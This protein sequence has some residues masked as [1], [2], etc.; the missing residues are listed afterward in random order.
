MRK[1]LMLAAVLLLA[2]VALC[3]C[4]YVPP[5]PPTYDEACTPS[6]DYYVELAAST[7]Y[8]EK[9]GA[10][11]VDPAEAEAYCTELVESRGWRFTT[12]PG[13]GGEDALWGSF[14]ITLPSEIP[15]IPM[16]DDFASRS[17]EARAAFKCH[18]GLH[19][20]QWEG[21]GTGEFLLTYALGEGTWAFETQAYR[22]NFRM[23]LRW[24]PDATLEEQ[25][26]AARSYAGKVF[27][28]PYDVENMPAKCGIEAG[29]EILMR[30]VA[31][32]R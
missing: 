16:P 4:R 12:L 18:E 26:E 3:S 5:S 13:E 30:D 6:H 19:T 9:L 17:P 8:I 29:T 15:V 32:A 24:N 1:K 11:P 20:F 27:G 14:G 10:I 7:K 22:V 28:K 25:R 31:Q 23:W 2:L 21:H